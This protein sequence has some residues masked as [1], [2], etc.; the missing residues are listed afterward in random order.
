M[1]K[2]MLTLSVRTLIS[3]LALPYYFNRCLSRRP[4]EGLD[5]MVFFSRLAVLCQSCFSSALLIISGRP[6]E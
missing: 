6:T 1:A 5:Q 4:P 3:M 2:C